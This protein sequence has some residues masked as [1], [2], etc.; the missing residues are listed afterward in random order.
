M[1]DS[2]KQKRV[3]KPELPMIR[4][5]ANVPDSAFHVYGC[6]GC[7]KESTTMWNL[8][9]VEHWVREPVS[10]REVVCGTGVYL[11]GYKP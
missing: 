10:Q 11:R 8:T 2:Q 9:G 4:S 5:W 1:G 3:K 6:T 7:S